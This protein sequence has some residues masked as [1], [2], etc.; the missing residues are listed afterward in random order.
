MTRALAALLALGAAAAHALPVE[1]LHDSGPANKRINVVI[2]GDGY[3]AQD[4]QQLTNDAM[5]AVAGLFQF[6]PYAEYRGFFNVKLVKVVSND[7]GADR[8][9]Y[10]MTRDT[11]LGATFFCGGIQ[12]LLCVNEATVLAVA[13]QNVPE[14]DQAI[15]LVN[16]P[17]YGGAGGTVATASL[18]PLSIDILRHELGH[19][20]ARLADEYETPGNGA[21][22]QLPDCP[23]PNVSALLPPSPLKWGVWISPGTPIP[24]ADG[25]SGIG[26]FD[27]A[28]FRTSGIYRPVDTACQMNQLGNRFCSVCREGMIRALYRSVSPIDGQSPAAAVSLGF[29]QS[30][31]LSTA[32]PGVVPPTW[33]YAWSSNGV[34]AGD[35]GAQYVAEAWRYADGTATVSVEVRD[36][37][38]S[39]RN[40]PANVLRATATWALTVDAGGQRCDDGLCD[41]AACDGQGSCARTPK[42]D[43]ISCGEPRCADGMLTPAP[44]CQTGACAEQPASSCGV[45][46]CN[47][48]GTA[49]LDACASDDDC[50]GEARCTGGRCALVSPA[51]GSIGGDR[52]RGAC[53]C[54]SGGATC[55]LLLALV[56]VRGGRSNR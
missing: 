55:L 50:T 24:T 12:R 20:F 46:R 41:T 36:V 48:A 4:Q 28:R 30:V 21:P 56:L 42:P 19:S 34:P 18:H 29:C 54:G 33:S 23:E 25:V 7:N 10:G 27:G 43:G 5:Q 45:Y 15:V 40:D 2:L 39:V 31:P 53:E 32:H 38:A 1:V 3:R 9:T 44:L 14:V 22:C 26:M 51:L 35:G 17:M 49:C 13:A 47:A 11:A 16:D 52:A 37:T 8:G 6:S